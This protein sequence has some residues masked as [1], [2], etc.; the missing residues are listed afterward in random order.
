[1]Y[2][3]TINKAEVKEGHGGKPSRDFSALCV[4]PSHRGHNIR[5]N[6]SVL[7]IF[8][9][10]GVVPAYTSYSTDSRK[11]HCSVQITGK[12]MNLLIWFLVLKKKKGGNRSF[13]VHRTT[14]GQ[15][16]KTKAVYFFPL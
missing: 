7:F 6:V 14:G 12:T 16:K 10:D 3:K 1:M 11:D 15:P 2:S 13:R 5:R 4:V 9:Y 8:K